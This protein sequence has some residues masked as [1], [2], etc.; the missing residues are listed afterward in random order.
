MGL[1][2]NIELMEINPT[3][4][5]GERISIKQEMNEGVKYIPAYRH[6]TCTYVGQMSR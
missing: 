4:P 5:R 2:L 3:W 6:Q 1:P